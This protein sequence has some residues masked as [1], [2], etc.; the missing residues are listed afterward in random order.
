MMDTLP[1]ELLRDICDCF[2]DKKNTL[3]AVRLVN[4]NLA[5]AAAP[6]LFQTL[7]VYQTPRSWEKLSSV[8]A[9]ECLAPYVVKVEVALLGY[10]PHYLDFEDW[11][12]STWKARWDK[13]YDNQNRAGLVSILMERFEKRPLRVLSNPDPQAE[14]EDWKQFPEVRKWHDQHDQGDG[15]SMISDP[16]NSH[17][18]LLP[19]LDSALGLEYRY[20]MYRYWHDGEN[21]LSEM[22][23]HPEGPHPPLQLVPFPR[24]REMKVL[25]PQELYM[26]MA[27]PSDVAHRKYRE[28]AVRTWSEPLVRKKEQRVLLSLALKM[29]DASGVNITRLELRRYRDILVDHTFP[30][31]PLK[32]LQELVLEFRYSMNY[33]RFTLHDVDRWKL[34]RWLRGA[35][36][37]RTLTIL[38]QDPER[39]STGRIL[40]V[41]AMFHG[42]E[43]PKLR[44]IRF[45]ETYVRLKSLQQFLSE[46]T[47]S[48]RSIRIEQ[49][50]SPKKEWSSIVSE[51]STLKIRSPGCVID[52]DNLGFYCPDKL[53]YLSTKIEED[54]C[55]Y[56]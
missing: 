53:P 51:L 36:N 3:K 2:K 50:I 20:E 52:M 48:L 25:R 34:P 43:W 9:H 29:F 17:V 37:L 45:K 49:P 16:Q 56:P 38:S 11:K 18:T 47:E 21:T 14:I 33:Q 44:S 24:L 41:I 12:Q 19:G 54:H 5:R 22:M 13:C 35:N 55:W 46:H 27:W 28:T 39:H 15:E 30:N 23:F 32:H 31:P 8:A 1:P 26:D 10:L 40:D 7:L 4:R 42:T 6:L